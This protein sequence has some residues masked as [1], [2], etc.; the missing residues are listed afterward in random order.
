M[1]E[2]AAQARLHQCCGADAK[3][4]RYRFGAM[5]RN[6]AVLPDLR[7]LSVSD[8]TGTRHVA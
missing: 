7:R 5:M 4:A 1:S 2:A 6:F 8:P 3:V